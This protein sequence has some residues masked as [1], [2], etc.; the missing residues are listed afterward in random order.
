M[1][2]CKPYIL[3]WIK[4]QNASGGSGSSIVID[5]SFNLSGSSFEEF[6]SWLANATFTGDLS[7]E[8]SNNSKLKNVPELKFVDVTAC[9]QT[10]SGCTALESVGIFDLSKC[11][12]VSSMFNNC[13]NLISVSSYNL[14]K[15]EKTTQMFQNCSNLETVPV[16]NLK[17]VLSVSDMFKNCS[18]LTNDSLNNILSSLDTFVDYYRTKTLQYI[19]LS[20]TQATTC[21]SFDI[22]T[23]LTT[24]GWTTG[25]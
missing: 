22:W 9:E 7:Y 11:T 2:N 19:G 21:T 17:K 12:N 16:F 15:V 20:E 5:K 14:E 10:F 23:S 4:N 6:P 8:F 1:E 13:N 25:Y 24:K 18:S 3:N